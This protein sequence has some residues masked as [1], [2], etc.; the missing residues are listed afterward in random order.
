MNRFPTLKGLKKVSLGGNTQKTERSE[1]PFRIIEVALRVFAVLRHKVNCRRSTNRKVGREKLGHGCA[2]VHN[3]MFH[4]IGTYRRPM[5][6]EYI[7]AII[8]C[9]LLFDLYFGD[10]CV[11][12]K[13]AQ[14]FFDISIARDLNTSRSIL[15]R[16]LNGGHWELFMN[17]KSI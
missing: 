12:S 6:S 8:L 5:M 10:G 4:Y 14:D 7:L 17:L 1:P 3:T 13:T 9:V 11:D 2:Y 15:N 16:G